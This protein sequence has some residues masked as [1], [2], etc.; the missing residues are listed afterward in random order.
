MS[1]PTFPISHLL[2][3]F[4]RKSREISSSL[5]CAIC[6]DLFYEPVATQCGHIFCKSCLLLATE[7]NMSCP[8]CRHPLKKDLVPE[9]A[10]QIWDFIQQ[11]YPDECA[12]RRTAAMS[13]PDAHHHQATRIESRRQLAIQRAELRRV[14]QT[15]RTILADANDPNAERYFRELEIELKR[16]AG[17]VVRCN[18]AQRFVCMQREVRRPG[19]DSLGRLYHRCPRPHPKGCKFFQWVV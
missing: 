7:R 11:T 9:V 16:P 17:E 1:H 8:A 19:H 14:M 5:Q 15:H 10:R 18:C 2:F 3:F 4:L 12:K 13:G 6:L